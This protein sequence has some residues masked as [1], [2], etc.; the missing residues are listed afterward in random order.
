MFNH[1]E[2]DH[3]SYQDSSTDQQLDNEKVETLICLEALLAI[4]YQVL[5]GLVHNQTVR[6]EYQQLEQHALFHQEE[7]KKI[8]LIPPKTESGIESKVYKYLLQFKPTY[9]P[10][11]SVIN[12][13]LH[14]ASF[15]MD[16]YKH[17]SYMLQEHH[18]RIHG[19]LEDNVEE[20][21]FLQQEKEFHQNRLKAYLKD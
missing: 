15:K 18:E 8:F 7:L 16:I 11:R 19:F 20:L 12:L 6:K 5:E 1:V 14:L 10:L 9:L 13:A 3:V 21:S 17:F 4:C 2:K